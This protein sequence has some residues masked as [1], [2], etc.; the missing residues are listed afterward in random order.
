MK[1]GLWD[2]CTA[3]QRARENAWLCFAFVEGRMDKMYS[4]A[5]ACCFTNSDGEHMCP[6]CEAASTGICSFSW[7]GS[8]L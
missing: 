3:S 1:Y 6:A 2:D 8:S 5:S 7:D 4:V